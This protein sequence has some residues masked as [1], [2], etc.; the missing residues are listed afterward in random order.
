MIRDAIEH[1]PDPVIM[2]RTGFYHQMLLALAH[3]PQFRA[4]QKEHPPPQ[5][6][7]CRNGFMSEVKT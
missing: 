1:I 3:S 2:P 7:L 4:I 6:I 5:L